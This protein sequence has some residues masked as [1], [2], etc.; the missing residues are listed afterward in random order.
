MSEPAPAAAQPQTDPQQ[1]LARARRTNAII[2]FAPSLIVLLSA[3]VPLLRRVDMND[4]DWLP[5]FSYAFEH[6]L[7]WGRDVIYTYGPWGFVWS[8]YD[9]RTFPLQCIFWTCAALICWWVMWTMARMSFGRSVFTAGVVLWALALTL[10]GDYMCS[11]DVRLMVLPVLLLIFHFFFRTSPTDPA[12]LALVALI[13]FTGLV[14][15]PYLVTGLAILLLISLDPVGPRLKRAIPAGVYFFTFIIGWLL[16]GQRLGDIPAHLHWSIV[17]TRAYDEAMVLWIPGELW[18][19]GYFLAIVTLLLVATSILAVRVLRWR[20][21][22]FMSGLLMMLYVGFRSG[23]IRHDWHEIIATGLL[24]Q[25]TLLLTMSAWPHLREWGFRILWG[26]C[27]AAAA[28]LSSKSLSDWHNSSL[29]QQMSSTLT[30]VAVEGSELIN[31]ATGGQSDNFTKWKKYTDAIV[32]TYSFPPVQGTVDLFPKDAVILLANGM[33][34][35]PRPTLQS[36]VAQTPELS[37]I[38]ADKFAGP[39][40]PDNIFFAINL[41]TL[42]MPTVNDTFTWLEVLARYRLAWVGKEYV[43]LV[44]RDVPRVPKLKLMV[45]GDAQF[46][47]QININRNANDSPGQLIWAQIEFRRKPS[48]VAMAKLYKA[49]EIAMVA[50]PNSGQGFAA[51][52]VPENASGGFL[53][54][55]LVFDTKTFALLEDSKPDPAS[56]EPMMPK[57]FVITGITGSDPSWYFENTMHIKLFGLTFENAP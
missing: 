3:F 34:Y 50:M 25:A 32:R 45:E 39:D 29:A 40:A 53:L 38:N 30:G 9:P 46:N 33:N 19:V 55:P 57:T 36:Y 24:L 11:P 6:G 23:F 7:A 48:G 13:S 49:P 16:A 37:R 41:G 43:L 10:G 4:L 31:L 14:K 20:T 44:K 15:F 17:L 42:N 21:I 2:C 51:R 35:S 56:W 18:Q 8:G 26:T 1:R 52:L 22:L 5:L 27:L 54:G 47:S 28:I 12:K